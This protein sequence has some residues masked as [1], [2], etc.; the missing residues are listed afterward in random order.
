MSHAAYY[1]ALLDL[2]SRFRRYGCVLGHFGFGIH[3]YIHRD[4]LYFTMLRDPVQRVIS[5]YF[6]ILRKRKRFLREISASGHA[7]L[8]KFVEKSRV[9]QMG[10]HQTRLLASVDDRYDAEP[11]GIEIGQAELARAKANLAERIGIIGLTE[12]F[13]ESLILY[14]KSFGWPDIRYVPRNVSAHKGLDIPENTIQHIREYNRFDFELYDF[15]KDLMRKQIEAY[16][17]DF[18]RDL[19]EFRALNA[20]YG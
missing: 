7:S 12:Q 19:R 20:A 16:D 18:Q 2:E 4:C 1:F 6:F 3:R 15:A 17:G 11:A 14:R 10:N 13:D 8:E 5:D 9:C